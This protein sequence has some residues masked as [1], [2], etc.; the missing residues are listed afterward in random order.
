MSQKKKIEIDSKELHDLEA[1]RKG[2]DNFAIIARTD[3]QGK[4]TY[5]ND[6]FCSVSGY[7]REELIGKDHRIINSGKHPKSFFKELWDTVLSGEIWRGE[8]CNKAKDNSLYWVNTTV[9]PLKSKAGEIEEFIAFRYLINEQKSHEE[10]LKGSLRFLEGI[11]NNASHA[12]V[13]SDKK[14]IITSFNK[15]AEEMLGYKA[16]EL[17][18]KETPAIWHD[19]EEVIMRSKQFS[20]ELG[21]NIEPGFGTFVCHTDLGKKN[22]FEWTYVRKDGTKFPVFISITAIKNEVGELIGYLGL[23]NDISDKRELE[24]EVH[25]KN[26][27]LE[28]AQS[29]AKIG[30]WNFDLTTGKISWSKEMYNIFPEN[31]EDGEPEF[32]KHRSSIHPEDVKHWESIVNKCVADGEPYKM[33]FR[34]YK[35]EDPSEFVYVEARGQG[36]LENGKVRWI[37]GTCQDITESVIRE[38]E[39]SLILES[40]KIGIWKFNPIIN[41]LHWDQS[42]Y[43]LFGVKQSDFSGAYDAW[44]KTLHEDSFEIAQKEFQEALAGDGHFDTNFKIKTPDGKVLYIGGRAIIDRDQNGRAVFVTGVNWDRTKEHEAMD[45]MK[46]AE[47]AK[48]EFL[49]NMSHEIRTPMNGIIG[50]L[51]LLKDTSLSDSQRNMLDTVLSS[52]ETLL[53][54]L[55]DILDIS[56]I[57]AGKLTFEKVDFDLDKAIKGISD[58]LAS[59]AT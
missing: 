57:E 39:L 32:E 53:T 9:L 52:S 38:R 49:A 28:S 43:E 12:I 46:K 37:S 18:G 14:G 23:A 20:K 8:V 13:S 29:L 55:S 22:E 35:K 48:S 10:R 1:Y 15:K 45:K 42:M 40:N 4:I 31:V 17:I 21:R 41:D 3:T 50:M 7:A 5:V 26:Q 36:F 54:I 24:K 30:S 6:L 44:L 16:D 2:L 25:K 51:D 34:T 27:M 19:L 33:I 11:Q 56:K 47:K 59:K 58:L